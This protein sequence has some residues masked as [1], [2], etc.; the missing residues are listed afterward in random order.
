MI[1]GGRHLVVAQG[2]DKQT[3][4]VD[5]NDPWP[6][7]GPVAVPLEA[8]VRLWTWLLSRPVD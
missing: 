4:S 7:I 3:Q 5:I 6:D 1:G 2:V 8:P